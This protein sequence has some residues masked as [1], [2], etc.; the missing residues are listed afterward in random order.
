MVR[1]QVPEGADV[2]L[3]CGDAFSLP[4]AGGTFDLVFHQGLLEHF[5]N[6]GDMLAEHHR[7]LREGGHILVDVPQRWH[8]YTA[9]KHAMIA[10]GKWFAG[11]ETEFSPRELEK[12]LREHS[13]TIEETYGEWLNPPIWYRILRKGTGAKLPMYPGIFTSTRKI[14]SGLRSAMLSLRPVLYTTVVIG[15]IARKD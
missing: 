3:C 1:S 10:A 15:T 13:F 8:Y 9:L 12:M 14:F 2:D 7:V 11:W 5:R 4:F 6:P